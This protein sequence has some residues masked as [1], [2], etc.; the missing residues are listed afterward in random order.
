MAGTEGV[1]GAFL[2]FW[3]TAESAIGAD[4]WEGLSPASQYLV[5]IGLM[6]DIPDKF[7]VGGIEDIVERHG[8][9][10]GAKAR[11]EVAW[12]GGKSVYNVAAQFGGQFG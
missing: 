9:F 4:S 6:A 2:H 1:V 11:S 12:M 8:Q 3:E 7:V 10:D 5:C